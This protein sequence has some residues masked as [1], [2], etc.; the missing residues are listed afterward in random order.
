[1]RRPKSKR[2][3]DIRFVLR[4][5]YALLLA[6]AYG[7]P[8]LATAFGSREELMAALKAK[9]TPAEWRRVTRSYRLALE[10]QTAR[11]VIQAIDS[12]KRFFPEHASATEHMLYGWLRKRSIPQRRTSTRRASAPA[13]PVHGEPVCLNTAPFSNAAGLR[14]TSSTA[15]RSK[16]H[17]EPAP[18][19]YAD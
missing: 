1:M 7:P 2:V 19:Q 16:L 13:V 14:Q 9:D 4:V 11:D 18:S 10:I 12:I 6:P 17:L 3:T 8:F 5:G 15:R